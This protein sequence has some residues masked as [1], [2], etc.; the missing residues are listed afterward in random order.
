MKKIAVLTYYKC[1][2]F[3]ANLQALSTYCFL[4]KKG[5]EPIFIDFRG[6]GPKKMGCVE[7]TQ[8]DTHIQFIDSF[9]RLQSVAC[10]SERDVENFVK[11][12]NIES[13]IVGSDAV[14]QHHPLISRI[15]RGRRRPFFVEKIGYGQKFPNIFWTGIP[16]DIPMAMMSVSSQNSEFNLFGPFL[17]RKMKS[18]LA[19]F[20]YISVRDSWTQDMVES[21][22]GKKVPVTP[23]PVFALNYNAAE[24]IPSKEIITQ[25]KKLPLDYCL[26]SL[27]SQVLSY[28]FLVE[29]KR[30]MSEK[31][32]ACVALTMPKG[33]KFKHPFDYEIAPP[34]SPIDWYALIK[35]SKGYIGNNMHPIIVCLHNSVP[36]VS[37]DNWGRTDFFNRKIK[38][39]S[40]KVLHIMSAFGV[41]SNHYYVEKNKYV[42]IS[43]DEI[44]NKI[45]N[46]PFEVVK[47]KADE[48][49]D[50]YVGMMN[51]ILINLEK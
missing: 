15:K 2:N 9:I 44:A 24:L 14:L 16:S 5:Y 43:P 51:E 13:I 48:F 28:D 45:F 39:S 41:E 49:Y 46:Y 23:D 30:V 11:S 31:G 10:R 33:V 19:R 17:K 36:C 40:S 34:L 37:L 47:K 21:I 12:E 4:K 7:K 18:C 50:R 38:D 3:G 26:I 6:N 1:A 8:Y 42:D 29:L 20:R 32:I 35:Y 25:E 27:K 22:I